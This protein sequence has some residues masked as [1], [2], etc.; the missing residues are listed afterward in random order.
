MKQDKVCWK[1]RKPTDP[2]SEDHYSI[3][4]AFQCVFRER[5]NQKN[6]KVVDMV[7]NEVAKL[8]F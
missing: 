6:Q 8:S 5:Y 3:R 2:G 7:S 4:M 1:N